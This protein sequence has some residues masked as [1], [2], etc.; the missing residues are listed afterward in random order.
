[1]QGAAARHHALCAIWRA[2][3][4]DMHQGVPPRMVQVPFG[5]LEPNV[6][7]RRSASCRC[8]NSCASTGVHRVSKSIRGGTCG[9]ASRRW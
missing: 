1:M 9:L 7:R 3:R 4:I 6:I 8:M 2:Q 5:G